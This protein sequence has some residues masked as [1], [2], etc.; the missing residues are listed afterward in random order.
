[1]LFET[2]EDTAK[3]YQYLREE[4]KT[5][6]GKPVMVRYIR[7]P[8]HAYWLFFGLV[9]CPGAIELVFFIICFATS[10]ITGC[11]LSLEIS[12]KIP[13]NQRLVIVLGRVDRWYVLVNGVLF[14]RFWRADGKIK[15]ENPVIP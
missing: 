15:M 7:M 2:D 6:R 12:C 10:L 1:M 9:N 13:Q 3:A 8:I 5:F 11:L 4:A 14:F